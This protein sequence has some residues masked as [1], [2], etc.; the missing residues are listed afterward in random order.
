MFISSDRSCTKQ[1]MSE[2]KPPTY[3]IVH[4]D[5]RPWMHGFEL[6]GELHETRQ[7]WW[8]NGIL[9]EQVFSRNGKREG[10]YKRWQR[11]G[12]ISEHRVYR[13]GELEKIQIW[14]LNGHLESQESY[15]DSKLEGDRKVWHENGI[16]RGVAF[17]RKGKMDGECKIWNEN[18]DL[19][20]H[21][22]YRNGELIDVNFNFTKRRVFLRIIRCFLMRRTRPKDSISDLAK[23][24][25][26]F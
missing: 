5:G 25:S 16:I 26:R 1:C 18:G 13:N 15:R 23:I 17:Y 12:Q 21:S 4:A 22:F 7:E 10:D 20:V 8:E 9:A 24:I 6:N 14:H 11:N 19:L 2:L 3:N